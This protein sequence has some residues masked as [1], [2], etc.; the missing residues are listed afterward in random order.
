MAQFFVLVRPFWFY[1]GFGY[2][3]MLVS[4]DPEWWLGS[5]HTIARLDS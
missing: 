3:L 5:I 2:R 4:W 1:R